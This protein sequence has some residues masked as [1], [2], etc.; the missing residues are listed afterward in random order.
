M[1]INLSE[2]LLSASKDYIDIRKDLFVV[3][4]LILHDARVV[5][6]A[7]GSNLR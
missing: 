2:Q 7:F 3:G 5:N 1:Q 6:N 4:Q